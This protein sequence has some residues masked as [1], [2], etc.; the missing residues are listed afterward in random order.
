MEHTKK[1]RLTRTERATLAFTII[2]AVDTGLFQVAGNNHAT[3]PCPLL[4]DLHDEVC[5]APTHCARYASRLELCWSSRVMEGRASARRTARI[6]LKAVMA[7]EAF[8][9][10]GGRA[11]AGWYSSSSSSS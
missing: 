6:W 7:L 3:G 2:M 10:V 9:E 4:Q 8:F 5:V 11:S 1:I